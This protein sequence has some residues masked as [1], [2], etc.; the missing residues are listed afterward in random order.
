MTMT[1]GVLVAFVLFARVA[2][3]QEPEGTLNKIKTSGVFT[4]GYLET[5]PPFSFPGP[6]RRP[7]G[8]SIDLC[9]YIAG[10]VQKQLGINLKLNWVPVTTDNRIDMVAQGKVDIECGTT[11][12]SLSRQERVD[13]SLMTFVD[14]GSLMTRADANLRGVSDLAGKRIAIIPGTTTEK[15]LAKFLKEQFVTV[16]L[17]PV[18]NHVEGRTALEKE[19]VDAFASDRG[20]L[21]GLAFTAR[22]PTR[23][24][25]ANLLF[26]YEPYGFMVRRNDAAFRLVVN[27]A[28]AELYRS[29]GI[30]PIYERWFGVFGSPSPALQAMYL[31]NGLPE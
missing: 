22:D 9:T 25:L 19:T 13:F 30:A 3:G 11:T 31:L 16:E 23:F 8:Y 15:A 4:L 12:A 17:V 20:I 6:D 26:S 18:K 7:V 28:L 10:F 1:A 5:A 29:G 21:I 2:Q 14:G 27:R 24:G